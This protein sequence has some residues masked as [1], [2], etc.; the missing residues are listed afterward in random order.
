MQGR[1]ENGYKILWRLNQ[2]ER[3]NLTNQ[4]YHREGLAPI[5]WAAVDQEQLDKTI[6]ADIN[7]CVA[8]N[9]FLLFFNAI[10][11]ENHRALVGW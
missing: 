8:M 6:F 1:Q 10:K 11:T 4:Q 9:E 2:V 3:D 7:E 5:L